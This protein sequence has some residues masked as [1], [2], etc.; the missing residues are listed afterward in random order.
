MRVL[1]LLLATFFLELTKKLLNARPVFDAVGKFPP[2]GARA[3]VASS[4]GDELGFGFA[5]NGFENR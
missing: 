3:M 4:F 2:Q 1:K 5:G